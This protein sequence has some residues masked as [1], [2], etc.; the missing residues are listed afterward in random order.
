MVVRATR[1]GMMGDRRGSV[2][3][4]AALLFPIAV[5][6]LVG[7]A[8]SYFY[9]RAVL[10]SERVAS[11]LSLMMAKRTTINDCDRTN[12]TGNLGNLFLAAEYMAEPLSLRNNGML[13][14]SGV[15]NPGTGATIGWQRSTTYKVDGVASEL[16]SQDGTPRLPEGIIV[17]PV[18]GIQVDTLIA[19]EL[20]YSFNAFA[21][22]RTVMPDLPGNITIRR[23]AYARGRWGSISNLNQVAG[24]AGLPKP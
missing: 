3:L 15:T 22:L 14:V 18:A 8:E 10:I 4:E 11:G 6:L 16:G 13:I 21:G 12:V 23:T 24:C 5:L 2:A 7:L 9:M 1:R 20:A 17:K 19:V